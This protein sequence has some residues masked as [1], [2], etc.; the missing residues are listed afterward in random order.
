MW[1]CSQAA[2]RSTS[3]ACCGATG[4]VPVN[5]S[6]ATSDHLEETSGTLAATDAHGHHHELGA[7]AL[8]FDQ[9]MAQ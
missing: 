3:K 6:K 5:S 4:R 9:R 8:A 1:A 7:A 2:R